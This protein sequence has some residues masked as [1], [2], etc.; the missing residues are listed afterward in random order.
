[1]YKALAFKEL[2][3]T[4]WIGGIVFAAMALVILDQIGGAADPWRLVSFGMLPIDPFESR[5][6]PFVHPGL[7]QNL[8]WV[9]GAGGLA[10]GFRQVLGESFRS[11]WLFLLHR[12]APRTGIMLTKL[13]VGAGLLVAATAIPV[14]ILAI[15]AAVPGTHAGP[16]DWRMTN[17]P[18]RIC[19]GATGV[20]LAA[21]LSG[22]R[23]A[24]WYATRL[25]PLALAALAMFWI[26]A[27]VWWP[28]TGWFVALVVDA[29][30]MAAILYTTRV[31]EY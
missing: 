1:M 5:K 24:R 12:P 13:V 30:Y 11:T 15:W 21:F 18:L 16:F 14:L 23:E 8:A 7:R 29:V 9:A 22:L 3:E 10:L 17:A 28:L 31:R 6:I 4:A 25:F 19:G 27:I 2:R 20:Y 26:Y